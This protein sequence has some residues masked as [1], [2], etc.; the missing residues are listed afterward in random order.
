MKSRWLVNLA[1]L[2]V[3][4]GIVWALHLT[5]EK[6]KS[7]APAEI[8]VS[9]LDPETINRI[10]IEFPAKAPVELEKRDGHWLLTKPY[11]ARAGK[12]EVNKILA[13]LGAAS[14]DRFDAKDPASYGLDHPALRLKLDAEEF[15]FGTFNPVSGQQYV[16]YKNAVYL[17]NTAYSEAA[18]IQIV[19]MLDKNLLGPGEEVTGF[20]FSHLEQWEKTR[21]SLALE[22]GKWKVS[23]PQA[24]PNQNEL[25]EWYQAN[26]TTLLATAV[27]PY[28]VDRKA[29]Y[30]SFEVKLKNGKT[31]HFD[32]VHESPELVLARP[33]EGLQYHFP[34]DLGF[35]ILN[36]PVGIKPE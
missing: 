10:S 3:V 23:A 12:E 26:W 5:S 32:K 30:P 16:G 7:A 36:P 35:V 14:V 18:S 34:Q 13:I 1:L 15:V 6:K 4:A 24:K 20:D 28:K 33:D 2:L 17:V 8:R 29:S 25:N 22:Q 31:I 27:E 11:A 19:E 9:A 21:L